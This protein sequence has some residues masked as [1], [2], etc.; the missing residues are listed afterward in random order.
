MIRRQKS[1]LSMEVGGLE[2]NLLDKGI[3]IVRK[4]ITVKVC[5]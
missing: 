2:E 4:Y 3:F 5:A 1:L